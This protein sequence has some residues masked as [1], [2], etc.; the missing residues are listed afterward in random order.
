[1][2]DETPNSIFS[3]H[4]IT[5]DPLFIEFKAELKEHLAEAP[6]FEATETQKD[7][8]RILS[9]IHTA[10]LE[11]F[12]LTLERT[13]AEVEDG[14][15]AFKKELEKLNRCIE[16]INALKTEMK[17]LEARS[18]MR[19]DERDRET[20]LREER[21]LS[22]IRSW[23]DEGTKTILQAI[24]DG[25]AMPQQRILG[26]IS[27][28]SD[29]GSQETMPRVSAIESVS[30]P[31]PRQAPA[32]IVAPRTPG[33]RPMARQSHEFAKQHPELQMSTTTNSVPDLLEEWYEPK[34]NTPS[35]VE[36]DRL[37]QTI[38]RGNPSLYKRRSVII[39]FIESLLRK[40]EF[41][42]ATRMELGIL[43]DSTRD[44]RHLSALCADLALRRNR[45]PMIERLEALWLAKQRERQQSS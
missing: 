32:P 26:S 11:S 20:R 27:A 43:L 14:V 25:G 36:R 19:A 29:L 6:Y 45:A 21:N 16:E 12:R 23:I 38:W 5:R 37:Y 24:T 30:S 1:M 39:N 42:G 44:K 41:R 40:K 22:S 3:K 31:S 13:I 8:A 18:E 28:T 2:S 35:V 7:V 9:P 34:G 17:A 4:E 10:K 15:G 33:P